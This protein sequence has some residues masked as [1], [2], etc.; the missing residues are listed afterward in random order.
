MDI[1]LKRLFEVLDHNA[2]LCGL[3]LVLVDEADM[4][5][6]VEDTPWRVAVAHHRKQIRGA[7]GLEQEEVTRT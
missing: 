4:V 6:I 7:L 2:R 3:V 1:D 5:E